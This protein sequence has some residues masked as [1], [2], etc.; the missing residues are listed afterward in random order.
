LL[1]QDVALV[2][3]QHTAVLRP[4]VFLL[5]GH[6]PDD[7]NNWLDAYEELADV[8]RHPSAPQIIACGLGEAESGVIGR[9]ASRAEFGYVAAPHAD[10]ASAAHSY[11]AFVRDC[12]LGFGQ[13]LAAGSTEFTVSGPDGF[14]SAAD[15]L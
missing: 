3:A 11:A 9:I 14:R 10:A 15:V 2:K 12:V 13:R 4:M 5:S 8:S 6:A 7:D 1:P